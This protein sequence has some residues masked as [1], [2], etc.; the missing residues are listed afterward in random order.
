MRKCCSTVGHGYVAASI[1]QG[2][3]PEWFFHIDLKTKAHQAKRYSIKKQIP[4]IPS[5]NGFS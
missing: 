4:F 5:K 3:I 1:F 2:F